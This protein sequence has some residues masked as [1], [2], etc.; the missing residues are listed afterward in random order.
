MKLLKGRLANHSTDFDL[1]NDMERSSLRWIEPKV[2]EQTYVGLSDQLDASLVNSF[3]LRSSHRTLLRYYFSLRNCGRVLEAHQAD[4]HS[5]QYLHIENFSHGRV[6][7]ARR[8]P[9]PVV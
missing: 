2:Q 3:S 9:Q 1:Y 7:L 5:K 8:G 4:R 6:L